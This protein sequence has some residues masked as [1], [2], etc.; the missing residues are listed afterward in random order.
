MRLAHSSST[1]ASHFPS[2]PACTPLN[3]LSLLSPPY[4]WRTS[5]RTKSSNEHSVIS[6]SVD[7]Y[8][9]AS[10]FKAPHSGGMPYSLIRA[11]SCARAALSFASKLPRKTRAPL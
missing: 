10:K 9:D 7:A 11:A 8:S 4:P 1:L 6:A 2:A 3:L 5:A